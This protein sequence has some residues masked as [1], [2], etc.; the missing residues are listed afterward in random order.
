MADRSAAFVFGASPS[1]PN[2]LSMEGNERRKKQ[3]K[4]VTIFKMP[5]PAD[6]STEASA[7]V[8]A[9][10]WVFVRWKAQAEPCIFFIFS[11]LCALNCG[12]VRKIEK[13]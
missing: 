4:T 5:L 2:A 1:F 8:E 11:Y 10:E 9:I 7:E 6:L 13:I 12:N 3:A